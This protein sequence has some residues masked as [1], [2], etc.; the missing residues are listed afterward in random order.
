MDK[1]YVYFVALMVFIFIIGIINKSQIITTVKSE[2]QKS[3]AIES[4]GRCYK[5]S[6][7]IGDSDE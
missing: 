1:H 4:E 3:R 2:A 6:L 7:P 5:L